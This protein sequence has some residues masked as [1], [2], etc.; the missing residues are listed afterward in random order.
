MDMRT[1]PFGAAPQRPGAEDVAKA[2]ELITVY[3]A[4]GRTTA[5]MLSAAEAADWDELVRLEAG[6][7]ELVAKLT[8]LE[9]DAPL[10]ERLRLRKVELIRKV[11]ADDAAIRAHTEP[12]LARLQAMLT[13]TR[14]SRGLLDAYGAPGA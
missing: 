1:P 3:E 12:C 5:R 10:P 8:R 6:C 11:L 13:S 9:N 14:R 2:D 7:A 4:L